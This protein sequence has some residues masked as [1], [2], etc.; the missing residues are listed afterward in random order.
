MSACPAPSVSPGRDRLDGSSGD[1]FGESGFGDANVA[2]D[3]DEPDLAL[4]DEAA[5]EAVGCAEQLGGLG[6]G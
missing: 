1:V 5:R 6:D 2:A 4:G 3:A